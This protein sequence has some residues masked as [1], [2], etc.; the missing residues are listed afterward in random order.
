MGKH[1]L[2]ILFIVILCSVSYANDV[3]PKDTNKYVLDK[4]T[5][6]IS[7]SPKYEVSVNKES[8]HPKSKKTNYGGSSFL[9]VGWRYDDAWAGFCPGCNLRRSRTYLKFDLSSIPDTA[10][11]NEAYL[12]LHQYMGWNYDRVEGGDEIGVYVVPDVDNNMNEWTEYSL[13]WNNAH[14][15][16]GPGKTKVI[17]S[18]TLDF[19]FPFPKENIQ[20][21]LSKDKISLAVKLV[22]EKPSRLH[23]FCGT[24]WDDTGSYAWDCHYDGPRLE[25]Y[26]SLPCTDYRNEADCSDQH[27]CTWCDS[28]KSGQLIR[29]GCVNK[30]Q[31]VHVCTEGVCG[32][33]CD[34]SS[35]WNNVCEG[36]I[37]KYSG[38]CGDNCNWNYESED[39]NA[40]DGWYRLNNTR[41][42]SGQLCSSREQEEKEYR[43]YSC[44]PS[45]CVYTVTETR[46]FNTEQLRD[47]YDVIECN[48]IQ[49]ISDPEYDEMTTELEDYVGTY[50]LNIENVPRFIKTIVGSE[51]INLFII[52]G[53]RRVV[54]YGLVSEKAKITDIEV[55]G[56]DNPT[57]KAYTNKKTFYNITGSSDPSAAFK[58][59]LD[60]KNLTYRG[61]K[62]LNKLKTGFLKFVS[63]FI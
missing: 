36:D 26:F 24:G 31:C 35:T 48:V 17:G 27:A 29:S 63:W 44:T 18:K 28:C 14:T 2:I 6:Y 13:T 52:V 38:S 57:I 25:V 45:K 19:W 4:D 9:A 11:I 61:V 34:S 54:K 12:V 15:E 56:L 60:S 43:D 21:A 16:W 23:A 55:G 50:N 59:A 58:E 62:F 10:T 42:A 46:W 32:A 49:N 40:K 3:S 53:G 7:L 33:K 39:C 22:D 20:A 1:F 30:E 5:G 8:F 51:R 37:R 47:E 41:T